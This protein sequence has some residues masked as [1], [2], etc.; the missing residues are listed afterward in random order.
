MYR[1]RMVITVARPDTGLFLGMAVYA[2]Y[3]ALSKQL[4]TKRNRLRVTSTILAATSL[5]PH[6]VIH[7][8]ILALAHIRHLH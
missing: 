7:H 1:Y 2:T 6:N 5:L 3:E 8:T 4:Q